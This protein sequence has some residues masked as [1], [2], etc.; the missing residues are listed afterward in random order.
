MHSKGEWV[1]DILFS[2]R[3]SPA[4][5]RNGSRGR[6]ILVALARLSRSLP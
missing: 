3:E 1:Y 2:L 5:E 6:L 4:P